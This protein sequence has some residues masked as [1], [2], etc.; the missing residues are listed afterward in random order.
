MSLL[1]L[2]LM[3]QPLS[4]P[5]PS[6]RELERVN[7]HR[8]T[9]RR[10]PAPEPGAEGT[11]LLSP[12]SKPDPREWLEVRRPQLLKEWTHILGKIA[13]A[14]E[15]LRWFGDV[16][17]VVEQSRREMDGYTRVDL[18]IPIEKD[19]LQRHLLLLPKGQGSGPFP[20]VIAWTSST[21]DYRETGGVVGRLPRQARLCGPHGL[22][23][24]PE[25]QER[26]ALEGSCRAGL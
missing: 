7:Y 13:P 4:I 23:L 2:F 21:P 26:D 6:T 8:V 25:L 14:P 15:D 24:H 5:P 19:F 9:S 17:K 12:L 20:V 11:P 3:A 1:A 16:T 18:D 10:S 22:V